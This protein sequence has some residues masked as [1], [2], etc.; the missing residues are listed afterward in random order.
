M[1]MNIWKC[2]MFTL[3]ESYGSW[4]TEKFNQSVNIYL[5]TRLTVWF[6]GFGLVSFV[7]TK[8]IL[9]ISQM[10]LH[11]DRGFSYPLV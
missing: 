11:Q 10:Y 1:A 2:K 7:L 3:Q 8:S 6:D 9:E 5:V 4:T